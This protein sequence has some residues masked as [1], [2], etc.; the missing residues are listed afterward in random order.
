MAEDIT[1]T[2]G[3]DATS[4]EKGMK[5]SSKNVKSMMGDINSNVGLLAS[6]GSIVAA[7]EMVKS[8]FNAVSSYIKGIIDNAVELRN[9]SNATGISTE[10]LQRL[11]II[12]QTSGTSLSTVATAFG[13][14]NKRA[15][16]A[17]IRGSE[18]NALFTKLNV[19]FNDVKDGSYNAINGLVDL[20]KAY[21]AGTDAATLAYY[22]NMMY[23]SSFQSLL[24][25]IKEGS[26]NVKKYGDSVIQSEHGSAEAAAHLSDNLNTLSASMG[27][28]WT[29]LVGGFYMF[30]EKIRWMIN[31]VMW[32]IVAEVRTHLPEFAGGMSQNQA[33]DWYATQMVKSM[34]PGLNKEERKAYLDYNLGLVDESKV[35]R[36]TA[37]F[38]ELISKGG[39]IGGTAGVK[40]TP[41]GLMEAR[42]A[43]TMQSM[44]GGDI[45]SAV[46]F[47]PAEKTAD[48]T[49]R[50]ANAIEVQNEILTS[51]QTIK[52]NSDFQP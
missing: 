28:I 45:V 8:A 39:E 50:T 25:L 36:V 27:N 51:G 40:L 7:V 46:G 47:S 24:P 5:D 30:F 37:K 1:V 3:A 43:S 48:N 9:L 42:A 38:N 22:G 23:G 4:L 20:A 18:L 52:Q 21:E 29:D 15:G 34:Q 31:S 6:V 26:I 12:A 44:G 32:A 13:E 35:S 11:Q 10:G 49:E 14:F 19:N 41:I 2:I 17:R 16:E 33:A